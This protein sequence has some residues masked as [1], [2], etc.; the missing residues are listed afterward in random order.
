ME[1]IKKNPMPVVIL[2]MVKRIM[3]SHTKPKPQSEK[4]RKTQNRNE[5]IAL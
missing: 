1:S 3:K 5:M 4:I 2:E